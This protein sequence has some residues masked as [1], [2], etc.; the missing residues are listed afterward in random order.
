MGR[1]DDVALVLA[2]LGQVHLQGHVADL[3]VQLLEGRR[4]FGGVHGRTISHARP[5]RAR[6]RRHPAWTGAG[7]RTRHFHEPAAPGSVGPCA[8]DLAS[9]GE[10]RRARRRSPRARRRPLSASRRPTTSRCLRRS[11]GR[12]HAAAAG[13]TPPPRRH[14]AARGRARRRAGAAAPLRR[15]RRPPRRRPSRPRRATPRS[16]STPSSAAA[17]LEATPSP[18]PSGAAGRANG[19]PDSFLPTLTGPI[20]LYH[21]STAEVGPAGP[22]APRP[23]RPVLPRRRASWS[24]ARTTR[25]T[26]TPASAAPSPSAS[27]RTSR[28][29]SSA[30]SSARATATSARP[31][32]GPPRPGA[33]QV[34]RRPRPG[35][36]G[37]SLPVAPRL[38]APAPSWGS[39]SCRAISDLSVSPSSTSLWIGA[40]RDGGSAASSRDTPLRFHANV[41]YYLDNSSNL[42][43]LQQTRR[44]T[45]ARSRCSRT[46]SPPAGCGSGWASTRRSSATPAPVP[47][48]PFAEYHAEIVTASR[49]PGVRGLSRTTSSNR[50]QHW[51]TLGLRA[52]VF[53]GLTLDAG[54][55]VGLR[56]VGYQ[57]G[58]PLA[59]YDLIFGLGYPVRHRGVREAGR[60]HAHGREGARA[61]DGDG[62]R[63]GEEQGGRQADRRG[64]GVVHGAAARARRDRSRRQLPER[65]RCRP[66]PADI[67]VA[68][69]G[70]EPATG[71]ANVVAGSAS[72]VE[73]AL[74]AEGRQRQRPRQ[75][76]PI[77]RGAPMA[78]TIRFNGPNTFEAHADAA[79]RVLGGAAGRPYRVSVEATGYPR[80][81]VPLDVAPGR[82]QQLD[83][84]LRPANADVTLTPQAIVLRV[85]IKFRTGAP[86]LAPGDQGRAGGGGRHPGRPP[87]DQDPAHRGA[88]ERRRRRARAATPPRS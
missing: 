80:K 29:S 7:R 15:P 44:P 24:R 3:A 50:D 69:A 12:P 58:P 88:L 73:V 71:K 19:D 82:D 51:L 5:P 25:A 42:V 11:A 78:A 36:Q 79:R 53:Q 17:S 9:P 41:N 23:P 10:R 33:D 21:I 56:S 13:R 59:P 32:A 75:G 6:G 55:D 1:R 77:A 83:V 64:G 67:T 84:T 2:L 76:R 20:G 45:R 66:G 40:G 34:V 38:H 65:A 52:R 16:R 61:V 30:R 54:V 22:P 74:V 35:R 86:K 87:R 4:R 62:G 43:R 8:A 26:R 72:T 28:S 70:F 46:A 27:R 68:A 81:D 37:A 39:G 49:R 47:L 63:L 14:A 31:R 48:R 18:V 57:Y 60:R 85:P